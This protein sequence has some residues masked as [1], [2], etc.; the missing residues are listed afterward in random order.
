MGSWSGQS[1]YEAW[2]I[3]GF[4]VAFTALP[5]MS[6]ALVDQDVPKHAVLLQHAVWLAEPRCCCSG[7][8]EA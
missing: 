2:S 8:R 4:N 3:M 7:A 1:M 5:V 6:L